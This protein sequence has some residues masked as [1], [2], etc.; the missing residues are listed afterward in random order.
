MPD[1]HA[2]LSPSA[3]ERWLACPASIRMTKEYTVPGESGDS[4]FAREGTIA[5]SLAEIEAAKAFGLITH[6]QYIR[7]VKAWLKEFDAQGYDTGTLRE[8]QGHVAAY[9]EFLSE[10][11]ARYP[12][13]SILLEQKLESGVPGCWGTSDAVIFSPAHVEIVDFKYGTGVRVDAEGNSQVRLYGCGA[14]STYGD[15]IGDTESITMTV[16]QP[17]LEHISSETLDPDELRA[18]RDEVAI[19]GAKLTE[20]PD[21]PFGPSE[22]VCRWCPVNAICTARVEAAI[23]EDF[24]DPFVDEP[25]TPDNPEVMSAEQLSQVLHHLP[26]IRAW[27]TAVEEAALTRAYQNEEKIPGWK[28]VRSGGT[29]KVSDQ[30]RVVRILLEK[31]YSKSDIINS[32]LKG[33][34]ELEKLVGKKVFPDLLGKYFPKSQGRESLAPEDDDR[35]AISPH[36][37]AVKDFED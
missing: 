28:V 27:C 7:K 3:S 14:L 11:M 4:V 23:E 22:S 1:S 29:R 26:E 34:G 10:R 9:V 19:P 31:G 33:V 16:F 6:K 17:R 2:S 24:G 12:D 8:M 37:E 36:S 15:L 5:H 32:K 21:A 20:D 30:D 18:W 35:P 13:S 25:L